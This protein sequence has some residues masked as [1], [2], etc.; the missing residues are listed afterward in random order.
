[1][2]TA[3]LSTL[4]RH[5]HQ[6]AARPDTRQASDGQLLEDF[7]AHRSE[8]AFATLVSRYGPM[9]LRVCRRVL[10]HEQDAEDAFQ[11]TFLVLA[12]NTTSIRKHAALAN[13]LYGVAQRTAMKA[14]RSAAR[15]RN[16]EARMRERTAPSAPSPTWDDVQAALDEEIQ[17]L[18]GTYRAAFLLCVLEGKSRTQAAAELGVREGTVW[19]RVSRAR[20]LLEQQL[21]RRGLKLAVVLAALSVA[22]RAARAGAP[23]RLLHATIRIGLSGAAGGPAA[24]VI[25]TH[26]AALAAGVTRA[27]FT[28][29]VKIATAV[30]LAAALLAGAG[31]LAHQTFAA[32]QPPEGNP[33]AEAAN[34]PSKPVRAN[35]KE[36]I[37]YGGRVLGPDGK[38]VAEA[39]LYLTRMDG[40]YREPF[41]AAV[42]ATTGAD[43]RFQFT[44]PSAEVG[45]RKTVLAATAA[46]HGV[47][48]VE[49]PPEGL[50]DD[51]TVRLVNDDVP[52]TGQVVDLEGKPVSGVTL[53]VL[54][55]QA[56]PGEDLSPWLDAA[57]TK[58]GGKTAPQKE[59]FRLDSVNLSNLSLKA[60]TDA[61]GRLRLSGIGRNRLVRAQLDGPT[62]ASR[63]LDLVTW[64]GKTIEVSQSNS[65][66]PSTITYYTAGFR[67]VAAPTKPV[68]G[69]VRDKD[70]GKPLAGIIVE[71]N[72]LANDRIPGRNITYTTTDAGGRY[73]LTGLPKGEGNKIRLVP[74]D[75]QP[76]VSVHA[77]VPDSPGL[78]A[79]TVDFE[80]KRGVWIEGKLTDKV[81]G[82]PVR[83][84]VDYFALDTN[85]NVKDHLG[86][87]GTIPPHWGIETKEDGSFRIVG[88][89]GPGLV[90]VF[91]TGQHLLAPDRDDEYGTK[92]RVLY[93]SGPRPLGLL[94]NYTALARIDPAKGADWVKRDIT[95][96]PGWTF[97]GMVLGP[98]GKPLKGTRAFGLHSRGWSFEA[99]RT[100]EFTVL[101]FNPRQPRDVFFRHAELELVGVAQ[102]PKENGGT[103]TV[104]M[105]P[106]AAIAGRLVDADGRPRPDVDLELTFRTTEGAVTTASPQRVKTDRDGRFRIGALLPRNGYQL[107]EGKPRQLPVGEG[108]S[109]G[110]TKDLGDVQLKET[111]Q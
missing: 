93:T 36:S 80:L 49:V 102:P 33:K 74:R 34:P 24:G 81:T 90:A 89:P 6:L 85:P 67:Y 11:A 94:I 50:R 32:T 16:H 72:K 105:E 73:R 101:A 25:P 91:Y 76:Y 1:M 58:Q 92:E 65:K 9:V 46:S 41:P 78:D 106:G 100:A 111:D 26:V 13:W 8:R 79:V 61:E 52:I 62:I 35:D 53:H 64:A 40:Y 70:T 43:G 12:R 51:L 3:Q 98:D 39:K 19:S 68:V 104:R 63:Y 30:L 75:D 10:R 27:M 31:A 87:E 97:T 48:W 86:F 66:L 84:S 77:V 110:K 5:L 42:Q 29:K 59:N 47:G 69:V 45:D 82:K 20:R 60:T 57:P 15:R 109:A 44:I 71:S 88:L 38:P 23:G 14:K 37:A 4:V 2:A 83:G 96:D 55:V 21:A 17:R 56:A 22:D 28:T 99:M 54:D 7:A 103:V 108:L 95:L 18:P 107:S